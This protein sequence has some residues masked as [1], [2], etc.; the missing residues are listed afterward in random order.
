MFLIL[1]T[2]PLACSKDI[3]RR[4][5]INYYLLFAVTCFE[6]IYI[7]AFASLFEPESVLLALGVCAATVSCL[8]VT[9]WFTPISDHILKFM[10]IGLVISL[11]MQVMFLVM[12]FFMSVIPETLMIVY[13]SLGVIGTGIFILVD[14]FVIMKPGLMDFDDY[15]LGALNLYF[16]I[17]RMFVYLLMLLGSRK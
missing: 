15:I 7:A 2:L 16:D 4:T 17:V 11:I 6:A 12:L 14:L 9:A 13:A 5:P 10:V 8:F 3:R 1:F